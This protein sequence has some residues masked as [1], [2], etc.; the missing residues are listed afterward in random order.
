M[1]LIETIKND[2]AAY[3]TTTLE[4]TLPSSFTFE[5]NIEQEKQFGDISSNIAMT[6]AKQIKKN[7]TMIAETIV[8]NFQHAYI[9]KIELAGPGFINIFLQQRTFVDLL[10]ALITKK[11]SFFKENPNK[12]YSYNVEFLSANP[13]GPIHLGNGRG[14][15]IGDVLA[16]VLKFLNNNV[17]KEYYINDAGNQINKLGMSLKI[18]CMQAAG[19]PI[20]MPEDSYHGDYLIEMAQDLITLHGSSIIERDDMFFADYAKNKI[21]AYLKT[22]LHNYGIEYDVW[23]SEKSLHE[24]GAI[25]KAIAL[26]TAK[27]Y[28]FEQD[29]AL[30]FRST[31][32]GDDKDRV[33]VKTTGEFTYTAADIAYMQNKI[34]RGATYMI[35]TLGHDHHSF[36][37]RLQGLHQALGIQNCPLE[38][39]LYQLVKMKQNDAQVRMSKR[40]GNAITLKDVIDTV[41]TDVA[42]FF[43]LHKKADAQLEFDLDLALKKTDENPVFYIQYAYVRAKSILNKAQ[44]QQIA[45]DTSATTSISAEEEPLL[46]KIAALQAVL[47]GIEVHHQPHLLANYTIELATL[48]HSYYNQTKIL[49]NQNKDII[50]AKLIVVEQFITT[51]KLCFSLMGI[52][53]PEKM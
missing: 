3:L 42:R 8:N 13:T 6:L 41:G 25:T 45:I 17:I 34:D 35:M 18:R 30:W 40:A 31:L 51:M 16:N 47:A 52:S 37:Q 5:L 26:L 43:Y 10:D 39:I 12:K 33:L 46:K 49:N 29:N 32:F 48:F 22:T 7:P 44:E 14:G 15:I 50:N 2:L 27:G 24:S 19:N 1:N 9:E 36:A 21:L 23:F 20:E 28:T 11:E 4:T 53:A 38:V